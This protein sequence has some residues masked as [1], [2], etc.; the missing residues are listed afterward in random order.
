MVNNT[1]CHYSV[2]AARVTTM[3]TNEIVRVAEIIEDRDE[4]DIPFQ[5]K[6]CTNTQIFYQTH[7]AT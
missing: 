4:M 6:N 2:L 5:M 7:S 1:G 3:D